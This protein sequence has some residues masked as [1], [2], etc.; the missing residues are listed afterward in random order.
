MQSILRTEPSSLRLSRVYT[1]AAKQRAQS[2]GAPAACIISTGMVAERE[3]GGGGGRACV[4]REY[5]VALETRVVTSFRVFSLRPKDGSIASFGCAPNRSLSKSTNGGGGGGG[6][7]S[8]S[9]ISVASSP[10]AAAARDCNRRSKRLGDNCFESR[11][12][13]R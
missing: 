13:F 3:G 8:S 2:G 9:L 1:H 4:T 10:S 11:R 12:T 6:G 7:G 5:N